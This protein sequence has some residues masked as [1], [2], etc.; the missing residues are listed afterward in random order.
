[1]VHNLIERFSDHATDLHEDIGNILVNPTLVNKTS[2]S[3]EETTTH[4]RALGFRRVGD[5]NWLARSID[6]SHAARSILETSDF[7]QAP[8]PTEYELFMKTLEKQRTQKVIKNTKG[9][10]AGGKAVENS[11]NF[12]GYSNSDVQKLLSL[13]GITAPTEDEANQAKYGCTCGLCLGG[14][15]SPRMAYI[16]SSNSSYNFVALV[17]LVECE[18]HS[19]QW[20]SAVLGG[21]PFCGQTDITTTV[22]YKCWEYIPGD[23]GKLILTLFSKDAARGHY[24]VRPPILFHVS[25]SQLTK[26][27]FQRCRHSHPGQDTA[28]FRC[29]SSST[30]SSEQ[31]S[32]RRINLGMQYTSGANPCDQSRSGICSIPSSWRQTDIGYRKTV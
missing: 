20:Q 13:R 24:Q 25:L 16:L 18:S 17:G 3:L 31:L 10:G 5:S 30:P 14:F 26:L 28:Y 22:A 2:L 9:K 27:D 23:A 21:I 19:Q 7:D 4:F 8:P 29:D 11:D 12:K 6:A 1:V 15:M 32:R